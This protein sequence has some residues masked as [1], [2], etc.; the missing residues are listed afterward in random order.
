MSLPRKELSGATKLVRG[1]ATLQEACRPHR[2]GS[3]LPTHSH[4]PPTGKSGSR[5]TQEVRGLCSWPAPPPT[6]EPVG[7]AGLGD[8]E[9]PACANCFQHPSL[10][11]HPPFP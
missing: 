6:R 7:D 10:R 4:T 2:E 1:R 8:T 9:E 11:R 3:T 5:G